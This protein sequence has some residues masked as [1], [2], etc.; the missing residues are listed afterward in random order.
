MYST[1]LSRRAEIDAVSAVNGIDIEEMAKANSEVIKAQG[2]PY[3]IKIE[4]D[5]ES[6]RLLKNVIE[7]T[8]P[9]FS[10]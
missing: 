3:E 9:K 2:K 6:I 4:K 5:E 8:I 7:K 10:L 1:I